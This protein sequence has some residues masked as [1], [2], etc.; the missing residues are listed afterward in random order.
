MRSL[1]I[2]LVG[3][4][5]HPC[6]RSPMPFIYAGV[7]LTDIGS[8]RLTSRSNALPPFWDKNFDFEF[9]DSQVKSIDIAIVEA[10][11]MMVPEELGSVQIPLSW[12]PYNFVVAEW[13]PIKPNR[14]LIDDI[15]VLALFHYCDLNVEPFTQERVPFSAKVPWE[16][17]EV[18]DKDLEEVWKPNS[19][20]TPPVEP[21]ARNLGQQSMQRAMFGT[22]NFQGTDIPMVEPA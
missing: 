5:H 14:A 17:N 2:K 21:S 9:Q 18:T 3:L 7:R 19:L 20:F 10:R 4:R 12:L 15:E 16:K 8:Y 11:L 13:I 22:F 1:H 6:K